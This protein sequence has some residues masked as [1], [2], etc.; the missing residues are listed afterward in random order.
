[1]DGLIWISP[2]PAAVIRF[3]FAVEIFLLLG[4]GEVFG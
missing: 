3:S 4:H 1:M 2:C